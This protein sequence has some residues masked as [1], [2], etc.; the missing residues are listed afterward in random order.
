MDYYPI[1]LNLKG[2][3][4]IIIGGG[5]VAQ[6]K[7]AGLLDTGAQITIVSPE[8]TDTIREYCQS[9]KVIWK[10][11]SFTQDDLEGMFLVIAAT[12]DPEMNKDVKRFVSTHQ[13][14]LMV[15]DPEESDFILPSVMNRGRLTLTVSTSG[16]SPTLT[17][18]IKG[19]LA[20]QYGPEYQEYVDF[21]YECRKW[22]LDEVKDVKTKQQLLTKITEPPFLMIENRKEAFMKLVQQ[23]IEEK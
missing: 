3:Q 5:K 6:R 17:K 22:I 13:L 16:A 4:V 11:K 1:Q 23:L 19:D 12:N 15:D 7:L 14:L 21:L 10:Q 8:I 20:Q 18:K 2:K 9:G